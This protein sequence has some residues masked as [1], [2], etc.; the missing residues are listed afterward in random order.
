MSKLLLVRHFLT[1]LLRSGLIVILAQAWECTPGKEL[2]WNFLSLFT[3]SGMLFLEVSLLAFLIQGN[4]ASGL[5][6]LTRTFIVSG[7]LVVLDI[8]LK[9]SILFFSKWIFTI[10]S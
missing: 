3:T 6:A 10:L 9:V 2:A 1:I 5:E 4:Y 7:V 8:L